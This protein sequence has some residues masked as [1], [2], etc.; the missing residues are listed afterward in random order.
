MDA[1]NILQSTKHIKMKQLELDFLEAPE[2]HANWIKTKD[3]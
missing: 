1:I 2:E 3:I